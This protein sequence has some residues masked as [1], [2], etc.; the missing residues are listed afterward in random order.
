MNY[1]QIVISVVILTCEAV[2]LWCPTHLFNKLL[3][4][5]YVLRQGWFLC[6]SILFWRTFFVWFFSFFFFFSDGHTADF[7]PQCLVP[8]LSCSPSPELTD[9]LFLW[10]YHGHSPSNWVQNLDSLNTR[11]LHS[12][13]LGELLNESKWI[14]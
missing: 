4:S 11:K 6:F 9:V 1:S 8:L 5:F 14:I 2:C 10:T 7:L 13:G 3:G 12:H